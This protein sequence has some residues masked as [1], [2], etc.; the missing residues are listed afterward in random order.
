VQYYDDGAGV[1]WSTAPATIDNINNLYIR[2]DLS[3]RNG[4]LP[5]VSQYR[6]RGREGSANFGKWVYQR[7]HAFKLIRCGYYDTAEEA[8]T[9][10]LKDW[11]EKTR[12]A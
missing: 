12:R 7:R 8:A 9:Q 11:K 1:D 10:G 3:K 4:R 2:I 5:F 6:P